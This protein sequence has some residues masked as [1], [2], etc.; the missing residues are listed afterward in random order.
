MGCVSIMF[1]QIGLFYKTDAIMK[2]VLLCAMLMNCISNYSMGQSSYSLNFD[3]ENYTIQSF[4]IDEKEYRVRAFEHI[5]Y[6]A[7]P[8]DTTFQKMNIYV[9]EE[10]Y[11]NKMLNGYSSETAPIFFPNGIGGYMPSAPLTLDKNNQR[12]IFGQLQGHRPRQG[13]HP[14]PP[15][16]GNM[17]NGSA[18]HTALSKG[19]VVASPGAR[20]RS[21]K[22]SEGVNTGKAPAGLIDLKAAV[23]Y[24]RYN[25]DLIPG[26]QEKIISNGTSAGGA[27]STLLGATGNSPDY[28]PYLEELGAANTQDHIF[29]VSAYCPIIDLDHADIAYEWQFNGVNTYQS[30]MMD[31]IEGVQPNNKISNDLSPVQIQISA[32]LKYLFPIYLNSLNLTDEQGNL[33]TL[34]TQGEGPFKEYVKSYV[35][36][37]AQR[38]LDNGQNLSSKP[39][40]KIRNNKVTDLDFTQYIFNMKRMKTPP[41]FDAFDLSAPENHLFGSISKDAQHF[42]AFSFNNAPNRTS[43]ADPQII[44]MMNPLYYIG[45][46]GSET[47]R[48]WHIR[49]GTIDNNTSLAIEV[50]LATLL[51]NK[52]YNV[53]FQLAWDRPHMGDYDLDELFTWLDSFC[54]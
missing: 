27:M 49:Y 24:L 52:G 41:A 32:D 22:N 2:N 13:N 39:W 33:L 42:T 4:K 7:N 25:A 29:A 5:I 50:I 48:F 16:A 6:V 43:I 11:N 21:L 38:A 40:F 44:K 46:P 8:V 20:G 26:D 30:F 34:D 18:I 28:S 15:M 37:S 51:Q 47:S 36:A 12:N 1:I 23:R 53:N 17:K 35:I 9:P 3:P 14:I 19:Y 54:R 10:Y 45:V 31:M